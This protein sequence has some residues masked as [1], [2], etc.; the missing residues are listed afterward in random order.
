MRPGSIITFLRAGTP[1][2]P[3]LLRQ[4]LRRALHIFLRSNLLAEIFGVLRVGQLGQRV[5]N[6]GVFRLRVLHHLHNVLR[7]GIQP[8]GCLVDVRAVRAVLH[9]ARP[10]CCQ[11][12]AE[13]RKPLLSENGKH[14]RKLRV[15]LLPIRAA[16]P[17]VFEHLRN[18]A[19]FRAE[20]RVDRKVNHAVRRVRHDLLHALRDHRERHA[21]HKAQR[22]CL[23][24]SDD[25]FAADR[26]RGVF[27]RAARQTERQ[28]SGVG[29]SL[30]LALG[31]G[32]GSHLRA[33]QRRAENVRRLHQRVAGKPHGL[34]DSLGDKRV[35]RAV[36]SAHRRVIYEAPDLAAHPR[37][38]FLDVLRG[39]GAEILR[40]VAR[41][42]PLGIGVDLLPL[43]RAHRIVRHGDHA[44]DRPGRLRRNGHGACQ[45]PRR[46]V[47]SERLRR[48]PVRSGIPL[49]VQLRLKIAQIGV[50]RLLALLGVEVVVYADLIIGHEG[51]FPVVLPAPLRLLHV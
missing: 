1:V 23:D 8:L 22:I 49:L 4:I 48:C 31:D 43:R 3:H 38:R 10:Q 25:P 18:P 34:A 45:R 47:L 14:G 35:H 9:A 41:L 46:R 20:R 19:L 37:I 12:A 16:G 15:L 27:Y 24:L 51:V 21:L 28:R 17:V 6:A 2:R 29:V 40:D 32:Q 50:R 44:R 26:L 33:H 13:E 7:R 11:R 30:F 36:R 5:Y 42:P 39:V